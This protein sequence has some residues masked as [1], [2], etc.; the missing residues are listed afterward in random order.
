MYCSGC[1]TV[2]NPGQT[3]CPQC[4]RPAAPPVPPVPG[5]DFQVQ[6]F[7][8]RVRALS[9]VWMIYAGLILVSGIVG[10][11]FARLWFSG[12]F[13]WWMHGP[14]PSGNVPP[15]WFGPAIL[16]LGWAWVIVRACLAVA[17]GWGLWE[18]AP[19]GRIVAIVA[20]WVSIFG[21][22]H[23]AFPFG[24]AIGIWTLIVLMGYRNRAL[25]EQL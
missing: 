11:T 19:W 6:Q 18:R 7:A 23:G 4:G 13:G 21:L 15:L 8:G 12:R 9:V 24:L 1:G 2:I 25:Y 10:M 17:A 16:R 3:F 14:W 22:F 5:L 20:A